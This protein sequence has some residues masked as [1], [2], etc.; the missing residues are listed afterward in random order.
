MRDGNCGTCQCELENPPPL[1]L[2]QI[3]KQDPKKQLRNRSLKL[4]SAKPSAVQPSMQRTNISS[5]RP[6]AWLGSDV[7]HKSAQAEFTHVGS[8]TTVRVAAV[9]IENMARNDSAALEEH[10]MANLDL[11]FVDEDPLA[12]QV[13]ALGSWFKGG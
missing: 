6:P 7:K 10:V 11:G 13:F 4:P 1:H 5:A 8:S 9:P 12:E 2:H 3:N